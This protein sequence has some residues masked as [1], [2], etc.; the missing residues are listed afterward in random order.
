MQL[1]SYILTY[2]SLKKREPLIALGSHQGTLIY[3]PEV[4]YCSFMSNITI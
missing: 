1:Q 2:S 4:L 3:A